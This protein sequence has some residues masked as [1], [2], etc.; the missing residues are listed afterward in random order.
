[1]PVDKRMGSTFGPP[2][3]RKMTVFIDDINMPVINEWGDHRSP[4]RSSRQ[5]D[6]ELWLLQPGE[7]GRLHH[8]RGHAVHGRHDPP[9]RRPNDIPQ[10]LKR[11]FQHLQLHAASNPSI[12][13]IFSVIGCASHT[14][15]SAASPEAV[16]L[17]R[18]WQGMINTVSEVVKDSSVLLLQACGSTS[19]AE[20]SRQRFVTFFADIGWFDKS[21]KRLVQEDLGDL[22]RGDEPDDASFEMPHHLRTDPNFRGPERP[23]ALLMG[24]YNESIRGA[25]MDLVF[26]Q[27][28]MTHLV[29]ISRIIST[30]RGNALLVGV[31]GS[32][33]QSLTRLA[34]FIAGYKTF[35]ITL[36]PVVQCVQ[37]DGGPEVPLPNRRPAGQRAS[38]S[39][40]RTTRSRMRA[41]WSTYLNNVLASGS[42]VVSNLFPR[43]EMD[44]ICQELIGV[45]KKEFPRRP[46]TNENLQDR[47]LKFPALISGL[48]QWTGSSA[49]RATPWVAVA[50]HFLSKFEIVC[51]ETVKHE[52][53]QTMGRCVHDGVAESCVDYFNRYRRSTHVTPK[54]YLSFLQGYKKRSTRTSC[55]IT[56][57]WQPA[58]TA[59]LRRL[60]EA[61]DSV[62]VLS[63]ELVVKGEG[64]CH[65]QQRSE[66]VLK[67]VA[68]QQQ[69]AQE[70][71]NKVQ[72]R[73]QAI[74]DS[75]AQDK[76]IA[77]GKL[78]AA[79]PALEAAEEGAEH[80]QAGRYCDGTEAGQTAATSSC[81]SWTAC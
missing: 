11:Q 49:G 55:S 52:L 16:R 63:E 42:G 1:L 28:A 68:I 29:K 62:K 10:R 70:V 5:A 19:A 66:E 14:A 59:V 69:A 60:L 71:K 13:K 8:H 24:Q 43:D 26:F 46:P 34:S 72:D 45:M 12:D 33:K 32:G 7:A 51:S 21:M 67:Q 17:C 50:D 31:G 77:E 39:C 40:S 9:R 27:D 64:A 56:R 54:S 37:P 53:I 81:A 58:W 57:A 44:E 80:H 79:R 48:P 23:P 74:V 6:G 3:G 4:T 36:T 47:A 41:S 35:Q 61:Q 2:A 30:P 78:E 18:I 75:I 76:A 38:P 20:S 73:A 15:R 25:G 22:P 65:R